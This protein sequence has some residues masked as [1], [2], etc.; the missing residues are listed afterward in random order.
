V[1]VVNNEDSVDA[2]H[3]EGV[4]MYRA[5]N[6]VMQQE[7]SAAKALSFLTDV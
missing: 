4:A 7:S 1:F 3:D 2:R 6:Y 5:F